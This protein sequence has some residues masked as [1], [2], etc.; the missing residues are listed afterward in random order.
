MII[1][2]QLYSKKAFAGTPPKVNSTVPAFTNVGPFTVSKLTNVV[3]GVAKDKTGGDV[4]LKMDI[5]YPQISSQPLPALPVIVYI[6]GGGWMSGTK[7]GCYKNDSYSRNLCDEQPSR[8]YIAVSIDYRL[9]SQAIFPAQIQDVKAA[10]R[11][12]RKNANSFSGFVIDTTRI[13]AIGGS[14]G[15]H[16]ASLLGTS[17]GVASLEGDL[18]SG[19]DSSV[20]AVAT[21]YGPSDLLQMD[22]QLTE[23]FGAGNFSPHNI[24]ASPE[25]KLLG[26]TINNST[27]CNSLAA[28][29]NP[30]TY[31]SSQAPPFIIRHGTGDTT[32]PYQQSK[33]LD[34]ALKASSAYS[35]YRALSQ[36]GHGFTVSKCTNR[37]TCLKDVNNAYKETIKFFDQVLR[38][39]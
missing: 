33:I 10:I 35:D 32:V 28:T 16:L 31:I 27:S 17:K 37:T 1:G 2:M 4:S 9:S 14:A 39:L 21:F 24:S 3:Y 23:S 13:A 20:Q 7:D 29:A 15:G 30:I 5:Y 36:V 26:C 25:S 18:N 22:A 38:G 8:G 34:E 12:L 11:F 19:F 6:H